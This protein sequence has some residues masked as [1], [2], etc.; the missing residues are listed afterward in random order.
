[1]RHIENGPR[2]HS[3]SRKSHAR[4]NQRLRGN[5]AVDIRPMINGAHAMEISALDRVVVAEQSEQP[6]RRH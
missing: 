4:L 3:A 5:E 1:M 2:H 6:M